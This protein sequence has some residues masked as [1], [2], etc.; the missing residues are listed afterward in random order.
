MACTWGA[1][2]HL[3]LDIHRHGMAPVIATLP[4]SGK[5]FVTLDVD[6]LDPSVMPVTV[7]LAPGGLMRWRIVEL[8]EALAAK[9]QILEPNLFEL[10]PKSHR[11]KN[12]RLT[13]RH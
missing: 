10:A 7:A 9:G 3:A 8:F 13:C 1:K 5:F 11:P 6:R 4:S 2:V 12:S